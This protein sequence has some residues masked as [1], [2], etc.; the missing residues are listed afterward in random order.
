MVATANE[1][2]EGVTDSDTT[3]FEVVPNLDSFEVDYSTEDNL[4]YRDPEGTGQVED[5][6]YTGSLGFIANTPYDVAYYDAQ[7]NLVYTDTSATADGSG[8]LRSTNPNTNDSVAYGTWTA[9]VFPNGATIPA[10][11]DSGAPPAEAIVDD[12]FEVVSWSTATL[13]DENGNPVTEYQMPGGSGMAYFQ[14]VD[15]DQNMDPNTI[16]TV[17]ITVSD[18]QTEDSETI[19][20]YETGPNTG[21]FAN[22]AAGSRYG[23]P[24]S[25]SAGTEENDGTL[26]TY[27]DSTIHIGY[28]DPNDR[29]DRSGDD[30]TIPTM[31]VI[32]SFGA[33][34]E[35]GRVVVAWQT[36]SEN[37]TIGFHLE[38]LNEKRGK[39]RRINKK[40]LPG[41]LVS[42]QGGT[43]RF[44][45]RKARPGNTYTYRLVEKEADGNRQIYGPYTVTVDD[46]ELYASPFCIR[47]L[48]VRQCG[49]RS[50]RTPGQKTAK[51]GKESQ[52]RTKPRTDGGNHPGGKTTHW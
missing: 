33:Y 3:T 43:Y 36:A 39:Y 11:Y 4:Y 51:K 22:N 30:A 45:D 7:G 41:L 29:D 24:L 5:I 25:T 28:I 46:P 32:A 1:G 49:R 8:F 19:T 27:G 47:N 50:A 18:S 9:V 21:V 42:P 31:A 16:E 48:P 14:V 15:A 38:R 17:T 23:L 44:V 40:L 35:N 52:T 10:T 13:T 37:G 26:Q 6:I 12:T 2:T 34:T 20:L